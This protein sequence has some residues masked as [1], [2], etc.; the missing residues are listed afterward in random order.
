[1]KKLLSTILIC[2]CIFFV[3]C[4]NSN[5]DFE[6]PE[7]TVTPTPE[8]ITTLLLGSAEHAESPAGVFLEDFADAVDTISVGEI[9]VIVYHDE[10]LGNETFLSRDIESGEVDLALLPLEKE[11][12]ASTVF[13]M[14]YVFNDSNVF[15]AMEVLQSNNYGYSGFPNQS[16]LSFVNCGSLYLTTETR[17]SA[18][19][20]F[21]VLPIT[22]DEDA[23]GEANDALNSRPPQG[24][25]TTGEDLAEEQLEPIKSYPV[26]LFE[27]EYEYYLIA[28]TKHAYS[29]KTL[30]V[31]P[32]T[33][34]NLTP[35]QMTVLHR[36]VELA[37]EK[38][39]EK[40]TNIEST[41]E[42][43]SS[44]MYTPEGLVA[45]V[46][47]LEP[48]SERLE[49]ASRWESLILSVL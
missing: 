2:T 41:H 28:D 14:P 24:S 15:E 4:S 13:S 37:Q 34:S 49:L 11:S 35:E 22:E 36:A 46:R 44:R 6:I 42:I 45:Y 26:T 47:N 27:D 10:L 1:M 9:K 32:I 17:G 25:E 20:L 21:G 48:I 23:Q 38:A 3:G 33:V 39:A 16:K 43:S 18:E 8:Y 19:E 31:S 30:T 12:I 7:P 5:A 29:V 40:F